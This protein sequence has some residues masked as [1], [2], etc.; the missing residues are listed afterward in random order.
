MKPDPSPNRL[1][2]IST[3]WALV[4]EAHDPARSDA[5]AARGVLLQRYAPAIRRYLG[6]ALGNVDA[7]EELAQD[8]AVRFLRGAFQ[9]A[10]QE[11]GRFR[12]FVKSALVRM[13][14]DFRRRQRRHP[15]LRTD[16]DPEPVVD[17]SA[18]EE[19]DREL[20]ERWRQ[21]ILDRTWTRLEKASQGSGLSAHKVLRYKADH[22]EARSPEMAAAMAAQLGRPVTEDAVRQALH[23]ARGQFAG[24]LREEVAATLTD[25]TDRNIDEELEELGLLAYCSPRRGERRVV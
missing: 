1:N 16:A 21:E 12:D 18:L 22:P 25:P 14:L 7:A 4:M 5:T 19:L 20:V 10:D 23:R 3:L 8:F 15:R 6:K 17:D 13:I 11:R 24:F 2:D 9:N